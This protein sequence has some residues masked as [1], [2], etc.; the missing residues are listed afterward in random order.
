M[1]VVRKAAVCVGTRS[2]G[3]ASPRCRPVQQRGRR[4]SSRPQNPGGNISP[5]TRLFGPCGSLAAPNLYCPS[6]LTTLYGDRQVEG[7]E[8]HE[9]AQQL[10]PSLT[11]P[12]Q[13]FVLTDLERIDRGPRPRSRASAANLNAYAQAGA[14][15]DTDPGFPPYGTT[16][17]LDLRPPRRRSACP[18]PMWMYDDG[19]GGTNLA[20]PATGGGG[21]WGHRDIILGSVRRPRPHGGRLRPLDDAALRRRRHRRHPVLHLGPGDPVAARRR[22]P[23]RRQ[24]SRSCPGR[25]ADVDHP[26]VGVRRVHEHHG[27]PERRPGGVPHEHHELQPAGRGDAATS[28]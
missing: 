9:P 22:L 26:A 27:V 6:G 8:P 24:R 18:W 21:C 17:R 2:S 16:G 12:E 23:L 5:G 14:N 11:P 25:L 1:S 4:R 7:R 13:L 3:P 28:R 20:C 19:P 10:D 15:A